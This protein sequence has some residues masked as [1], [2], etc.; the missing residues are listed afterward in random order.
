MSAVFRRLADTEHICTS[1]STI[2]FNICRLFKTDCDL[3]KKRPEG[4]GTLLAK[5]D[6]S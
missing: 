6:P 1:G 2:E 3:N 4:E 5:N